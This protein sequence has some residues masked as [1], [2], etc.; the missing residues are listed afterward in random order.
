LLAVIGLATNYVA[1]RFYLSALME[2]T[3][4]F[5]ELKHL[6][7]PPGMSAEDLAR[8]GWVWTDKASCFAHFE[9]E[10]PPGVVRI[11]CFGGSFPY[12]ADVDAESDYPAALQQIFRERGFADVQ[13][14]NF[15]QPWYGCQQAFMLWDSV[16]RRFD[17][18]CVVLGPATLDSD[19]DLTFNHSAGTR[20]YTL[21][22]RY[23]LEGDGVRRIDLDGDTP[24]ERVDGYY[25]FFQPLRYLRY[26]RAAPMFLRSLVGRNRTIANP[27]YYDA[28]SEHEES[29][30]LWLRLLRKIPES[31]KR[32]LMVEI[33]GARLRTSLGERTA[34][35]IVAWP[36]FPYWTP[37]NHL[38]RDGNRL[39]ADFVFNA[40]TGRAECFV[41]TF[42]TADVDAR[43][44][45]PSSA[46]R[47][48]L[49][50]F[51]GVALVRDERKLGAFGVQTG[52]AVR[53]V[54]S[55][56]EGHVQALLALTA[57]ST[58]CDAYYLP[59]PYHLD[60][61]ARLALFCEETGESIELARVEAPFP[62]LPI[63]VADLGDFVGALRTW[64]ASGALFG[65][66]RGPL[67]E[68]VRRL[69]AGGRVTLRLGDHVL[70][71]A[72]LRGSLFL[73][74]A[75]SP[76]VIRS[77]VTDPLAGT[78][79]GDQGTLWLALE[80]ENGQE[81]RV[82][83]GRWSRRL[84]Q[85]D[86]GGSLPL[87]DLP[88]VPL[89]EYERV[90][91]ETGA[92]ESGHFVLHENGT[93]RA[94]TS[95]QGEKVQALLALPTAGS[96]LDAL[97]FPLPAALDRKLFL[98]VEGE[99]G[100][101]DLPVPVRRPSLSIDLWV[102]GRI[103]FLEPAVRQPDGRWGCQPRKWLQEGSASLTL[104]VG[105][106]PLARFERDPE[107]GLFLAQPLTPRTL[108]FEGE[109]PRSGEPYHLV[110]EGKGGAD[111]LTLHRLQR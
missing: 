49:D 6:E 92:G 75:A 32:L 23:V 86:L 107:S 106:E 78:Q 12:G 53:F 2:E 9:T 69:A 96:L 61:G 87:L 59:I 109:E 101:T 35:I 34:S 80:R 14:L 25:R 55:F 22:S 45:A 5:G 51:R 8:V 33:D 64:V 57:G 91:L 16:G 39:F 67:A 71:H 85:Y 40:L 10:K 104:R 83:F 18:D 88:H 102:A 110:F 65:N 41:E 56:R 44:A 76:L 47:E 94:L 93:A 62:E 100:S 11:G 13:V 42:R 72:E 3:G 28:R 68:R 97:L 95:F 98:H 38:N 30:E 52:F 46:E 60:P 70:A 84:A 81:L 21:H 66:P 90:A 79:F 103:P 26:D 19:R 82:P 73:T 77:E 24:S 17:L 43:A 7:P 89:D 99:A 74:P 1:Y 31:G 20:M 36:G 111:F 108:T 58:L 63:R 105:E 54:Q 15:G 27:F 37:R 50:S 48:P 29:V 4:G